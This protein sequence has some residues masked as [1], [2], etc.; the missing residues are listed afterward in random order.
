MKKFYLLPLFIFCL[1]IFVSNSSIVNA[2]TWE[3]L[4]EFCYNNQNKSDRANQNVTMQ[5]FVTYYDIITQMLSQYENL[6]DYNSFMIK[7]Y[8]SSGT[9][10]IYNIALVKNATGFGRWNSN[11]QLKFYGTTSYKF[12]SVQCTDANLTNASVWQSSNN[13]SGTGDWQCPIDNIYGSVGLYEGATST[14]LTGTGIFAQNYYNAIT[15]NDV[16]I[17]NTSTIPFN[18][19]QGLLGLSYDY[20]NISYKLYTQSDTYVADLTAVYSSG[21]SGY[22]FHLLLDTINLI[23]TGYYKIIMYEN[24]TIIYTSDI[25]KITKS[26]IPQARRHNK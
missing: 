3:D 2:Y 24:D 10:K 21:G 11:S 19:Q 6:D 4:H 20:N 1:G 25:F 15:S 5:R 17:T 22:T 18:L 8:S 26:R 23:N 12:Y 7:M 16:T 14:F 9:Q 13:K